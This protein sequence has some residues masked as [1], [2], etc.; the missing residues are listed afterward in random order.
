[1]ST[2]WLV[3]VCLISLL[4]CAPKAPAAPDPATP[5]AA[6]VPTV[7]AVPG[8]ADALPILV[9]TAAEAEAHAGKVVHVRGRSLPS[10]FEGWA[11]VALQLPSGGLVVLRPSAPDGHDA[12]RQAMQ[13]RPIGG[14]F[15]AIGRIGM[16]PAKAGQAEFATLT[17][18]GAPN[19]AIAA[20]P[21]EVQVGVW[22]ASSATEQAVAP[23]VRVPLASNGYTW[24]S[25]LRDEAGTLQLQADGVG[26]H[27]IAVEEPV[28]TVHEVIALDADGDSLFELAIVLSTRS[29]SKRCVVVG[30][31]G[32]RVAALETRLGGAVTAEAIFAALGTAG[33]PT[34]LAGPGGADVAR[35][36]W[37]EASL[38]AAPLATLRL[39]GAR[40]FATDEATAALDA[41]A[42]RALLRLRAAQGNITLDARCEGAWRAIASRPMGPSAPALPVALTLVGELVARQ[43]DAVGAACGH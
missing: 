1:M 42:G 4:A 38:G 43:G 24:W 7:E 15:D 35:V 27:P 37:D 28:A 32:R 16:L 22:P 20:T 5:A 9:T 17:L 8:R 40:F 34:L 30:A 31:T 25:L 23:M 2:R 21:D 26:R 29:G 6:T 10:T 12:L 13:A 33:W 19:A 39:T 18:Q 41:P 11:T 3:L 36:L 14:R